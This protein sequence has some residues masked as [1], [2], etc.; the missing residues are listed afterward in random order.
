MLG[1]STPKGWETEDGWPSYTEHGGSTED[2][3]AEEGSVAHE[4]VARE[5]EGGGGEKR[6]G[7]GW[8]CYLLFKYR[9][10]FSYI[11]YR[12]KDKKSRSSGKNSHFISPLSALLNLTLPFHPSVP[13]I[14]LSSLANWLQM[15]NLVNVRGLIASLT[16]LR[17]PPLPPLPPLPHPTEISHCP[18]PSSPPRTVLIKIEDTSDTT[19]QP[20]MNDYSPWTLSPH[21][22]PSLSI[23]PVSSPMP[24]SPPLPFS[25][26]SPSSPSSPL[27]FAPSPSSSPRLPTPTA[28]KPKT[29]AGLTLPLLLNKK[30]K[31]KEKEEKE[32][33]EEEEKKK[34]R[35]R[36]KR[37]N[38]LTLI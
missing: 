10:I 2:P 30:E 28:K 20:P 19:I 35:R 22:S 3:V 37:R 27:T 17:P 9:C 31:E 14:F 13:L 12:A 29:T 1:V 23:T 24:I 6:Q 33:K 21:P 15:S 5:R 8:F 7:A 18:I 32:E 34:K 36:R 16:P 26:S 4:Y 11:C 38:V 25:P